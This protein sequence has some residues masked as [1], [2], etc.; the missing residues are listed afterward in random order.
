MNGFAGLALAA[1]ALSPA[2]PPRTDGSGDLLPD[3]AVARFG[4]ARWRHG[5]GIAGSALSPDGKHLATVSG[6]T[7]AVWDLAGGRVVQRFHFDGVR[8][9]TPGLTFSPDGRRLA[10]VCN[11]E[12]AGVWDLPTG[13]EVR[14]FG[15]ENAFSTA[16]CRFTPD[17]RGLVVAGRQRLMTYDLETGRELRSATAEMVSCL[18]PDGRTYAR[19][20]PYAHPGPGGSVALGDVETGRETLRLDLQAKND[21]SENGLAFAPDGKTLAVV[22][23]QKEI[24]LRNLPD[25]SLRVSFPLPDSARWRPTA[26]TTD[27]WQYRVGFSPDGRT[28]LLE[29]R[30]GF[31]HR[32]DLAAGKELPPLGMHVGPVTG[33]HILPDG[34]TLVSTGEDGTIR[35]WD[36]ESGRQRSGEP[37]GYLGQTYAAFSADGRWAALADQRGRVELWDT[38]TGQVRQRL[39]HDGPAV[40]AITFAPDGR[41]LAVGLASGEVQLYDV[42]SGRPGTVLRW[43]GRLGWTFARTMLFSPD[44][45]H[46]F[47]CNYPYETRLYEVATGRQLWR[48]PDVFAS[49]FTPDGA[50]LAAVLVGPNVGLFEAATGRERFRARLEV[51]LA[52]DGIGG[53]ID[54]LAYSP[55]GRRL[56]ASPWDGTVRLCNARTGAELLQ[57][58]AADER[59]GPFFDSHP[60]HGYHVASL[61]FSPD[62]KWLLSGGSDRSVRV[63]EAA[64]LQQVL[65]RD[66]H[67][68]EVS[69]VA[70]GPGLRTA[71]SGGAD[72]QA[73]RW[74]LRPP[75]GPPRTVEELWADLA[76]DAPAAYRAVWA[77]SD[78]ARSAGEF[79]RGQVRPVEPV[80]PGRLAKLVADLDSD[81]YAA[82]SAA[83]KEL[84]AL[85]DLA[86]ALTEALKAA[87]SLD[88]RRRLETLLN[89]LDRPPSPAQLREL[90]AVQALELA[91]TAEAQTVL[92]AWAA[93]SPGAR[94]TEDAKSALRRLGRD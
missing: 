80:A 82:R 60:S 53:V 14:R 66:G 54:A 41:S 81:R 73:Y 23:Q 83:E 10:C 72:G 67:E 29:A 59:K 70:F 48:G 33:A 36:L 69:S 20:L 78:D 4:C 7:V 1:L 46:L 88:K 34:W 57:A 9:S 18:S 94:L 90:R 2:V 11:S 77:L 85:G 55:D 62:G 89:A 91:G 26:D 87:P 27:H 52:N 3:G 22:H 58:K 63:W 84:A 30:G 37:E 25:G 31:I 16:A 43:E 50:T 56:A 35:F 19:V 79:L 51:P 93:G 24:Q 21:G 6:N 40:I 64:T 76:G 38:A 39:R 74:D 15:G 45:R 49:A 75:A 12:F 65:R 28:L 47:V 42:P 5:D 68:R 61:A 86:A 32:W 8:Y 13:R 17:G 71:F 92:Q 44:S